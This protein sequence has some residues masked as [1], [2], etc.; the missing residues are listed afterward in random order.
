MLLPVSNVPCVQTVSHHGVITNYLMSA[1]Q[2]LTNFQLGSILCMRRVE[3]RETF[4]M[5]L[6]CDK[7][8]LR[9]LILIGSLPAESPGPWR[10]KLLTANKCCRLTIPMEQTQ[11]CELWF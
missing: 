5:A 8:L 3:E 7:L 11:C 1:N 2:L 6:L 4:I 10:C 9:M